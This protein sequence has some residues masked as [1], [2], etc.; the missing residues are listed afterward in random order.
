MNDVKQMHDS[1]REREHFT[2]IKVYHNVILGAAT[3]KYDVL[4]N[5][6][7]NNLIR[8]IAVDMGINRTIRENYKFGILAT[9]YK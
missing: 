1:I 8:S 9:M 5:K 3:M 4:G 7:E 6:V 2:C